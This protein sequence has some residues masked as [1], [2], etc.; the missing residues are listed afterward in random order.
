MLMIYD[1]EINFIH[2]Y[3]VQD[4]IYYLLNYNYPLIY[5]YI[6]NQN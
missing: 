5:H 3:S 4:K 6:F 2:F 1:E